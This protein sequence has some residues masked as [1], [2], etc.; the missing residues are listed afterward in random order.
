MAHVSNQRRQGNDSTETVVKS[1][2]VWMK[3]SLLRNL[4]P[5]QVV[6][7]ELLDLVAAESSVVT[8]PEGHVVYEVGDV[9]EDL[10]IVLEGRVEHALTP[11]SNAK[12]L[13]KIVMPQGIFGF[14]ALIKRMPYR[15]AKAT[16]LDHDT[17]LLRIH[18]S[19][20]LQILEKDRKSGDTAMSRI[21]AIVSQD[22][23][24]PDWFPNRLP[25]SR[26]PSGL[27]LSMYRLSQWLRSPQPY[28]MFF[29][30]GLL[31]SFWY[32]ASE[33]WKLPR[34]R[35]TPG[36]TEVLQEWFSPNPVYGLSFYTP[37]YY[38][39]ILFSLRRIAEAFFLASAIGVPF[40]LLLGWSKPFRDYVF[41]IFEVLRP[42]PTLAWVPLALLMFS[43]QETPV[44]FL[45]F[46]APFFA[47]ALNTMLGVQSIDESYIRAAASLGASRR[48]IFYHV[49]VPGAMPYIFTGLQI[50]I[51]VAWFS[52]V[53]AEMVSGQ[54]GL[55]Y[56][57]NTSYT[58]VRYP[59]I[60][61]GM[62]TLGAVGYATSALV[63]YAGDFLMQ[64]RGRELAM[65]FKK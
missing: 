45:A 48:Q 14:A 3:R 58:T 38:T 6:S 20:L 24:I 2:Q 10:Y 15:L 44:I 19:N 64:W 49:I 62:A 50:A 32:F 25:R 63:G 60:I 39:H 37:D 30:F 33:V 59:T 46:L 56:V 34:F 22:Y 17:R 31:L 35:E 57:I 55:G 1:P 28:L 36:P 47:T 51:G 12:E 23:S 26:E 8:Y 21:A 53:A 29:G 27:A 11:D 65:G 4:M 52:L 7:E 61:I 9:G 16:C 41:P 5:F 54:Y 40:G 13:V 42:I 43:G 18:G